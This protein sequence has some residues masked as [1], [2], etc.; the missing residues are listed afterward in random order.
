MLRSFLGSDQLK[1]FGPTIAGLIR[2]GIEPERVTLYD[3]RVE[4][5]RPDTMKLIKD[6]YTKFGAEGK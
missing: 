4:G 5:G 3:T 6:A 1:T 2:D